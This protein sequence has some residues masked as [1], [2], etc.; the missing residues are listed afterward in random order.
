LVLRPVLGVVQRAKS[1][2]RWSP[3]GAQR[4]PKWSPKWRRNR[5]GFK[6]TGG[7][8]PETQKGAER[9]PK[10]SRNG[11]QNGDEI[12][13]VLGCVSGQSW[14]WSRGHS[15]RAQSGICCAGA[16]VATSEERERGSEKRAKRKPKL[17]RK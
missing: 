13:A 7:G 4:E 2:P 9:E 6:A 8:G 15:G 11:A 10:G 16:V 14:R 5:K 3:K 12:E 17:S 1:E